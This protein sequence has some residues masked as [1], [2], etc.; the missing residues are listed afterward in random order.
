[1]HVRSWLPVPVLVLA[2]V[3][4]AS[5][6]L[7][8]PLPAPNAQGILETPN[9]MT[10]YTYAPDG[11]STGVS[12]CTGPCASVWPPYLADPGAHLPQG[13]SLVTRPGQTMQW[14]YHG[15]PLYRY[16]AD[17]KPGE[18]LGDGVNGVWHVARIH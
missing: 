5:S 14:S 16:A 18:M 11:S 17:S 15:Q 1:M 6:A 7:A 9:G 12:H 8:S 3:L 13:F 4:P 10:L 2:L